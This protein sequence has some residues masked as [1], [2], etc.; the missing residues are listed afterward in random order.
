MNR[1][2][3]FVLLT[4]LSILALGSCA[5]HPDLGLGPKGAIE[6]PKDKIVYDDGDTITFDDITIRV[7]G[8]D[9]PEI[10]HP[11]HGFQVD[12]PYGREAAARAEELM[13]GAGHVSYLPYQRDQYDRLLAHLFIDGELLGLT[14]IREGL[15]YETVSHYGDNGF[16]A[17][18]AAL[19]E[20]AEEAGEP[21]FK[22]PYQWRQENRK[23]RAAE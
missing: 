11:E 17:L 13:R 5:H 3:P 1:R 20:A 9:T 14:L 8:I 15:A 7:L 6:I 16:P 23:E 10:S 21:P 22:P 2:L 18:A 4:I 19:L 12:Q